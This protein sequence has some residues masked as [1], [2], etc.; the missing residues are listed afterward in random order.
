MA[1]IQS[2]SWPP[3]SVP[4]LGQNF[5]PEREMNNEAMG[6]F[7]GK[8]DCTIFLFCPLRNTFISGGS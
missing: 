4:D 3:Y 2:D 5:N 7:D 8:A 1:D 6:E